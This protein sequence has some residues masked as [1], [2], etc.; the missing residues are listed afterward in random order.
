[1]PIV[2]FINDWKGGDYYRAMLEGWLFSF[3]PDIQIRFLNTNVR[4]HDIFE[5][6]LILRAC[7][8]NF[9]EDTVFVIGVKSIV[10]EEQGYI[11]AHIQ[12]RHV[13]CANNGILSFLTDKLPEEIYSLPYINTTFAEKDV[14]LPA[15]MHLLEHKK[16]N[17][18]AEPSTEIVK[19]SNLFPSFS[20]NTL[21]GMVIYNDVYGNAITN[22]SNTYFERCA[23]GRKILHLPRYSP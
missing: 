16:I 18:I 2:A 19:M 6:G 5:A 4:Q 17:E 8:L 14:F 21:I 13:F 20:N 1:M 3:N 23:A 11:Y 9:P 10:S 22:I 15:I 12:N 7:F